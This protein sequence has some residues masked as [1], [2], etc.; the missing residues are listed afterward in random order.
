MKYPT[1]A[2]HISFFHSHFKTYNHILRLDS[3]SWNYSIK[4]MLKSSEKIMSGCRK[5]LWSAVCCLY[6]FPMFIFLF[7]LLGFCKFF[8]M[9]YFSERQR[10]HVSIPSWYL[11]HFFM[12]S[13]FIGRGDLGFGCVKFLIKNHTI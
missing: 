4:R 12:I 1:L 2:G 5:L 9:K 6:L 11:Q 7:R 8:T 3:Y 13:H 10:C